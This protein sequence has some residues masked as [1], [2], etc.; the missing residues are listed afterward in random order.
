MSTSGSKENVKNKELEYC[1]THHYYHVLLLLLLLLLLLYYYYYYLIF[2]SSFLFAS[3]CEC[4]HFLI[5]F[6]FPPGVDS[7][8]CFYA[9]VRQCLYIYF[10][11]S[12]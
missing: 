2:V 12:S 10:F 1:H 3:F 8:D 11:F 7:N 6:G 4:L 5:G 9:C